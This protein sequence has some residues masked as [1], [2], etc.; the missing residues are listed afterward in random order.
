[1]TSFERTTAFVKWTVLRLI[2]ALRL[3]RSEFC[4]ADIFTKAVDKDTFFRMRNAMHNSSADE[5]VKLLAIRM[6][7]QPAIKKLA[8][9]FATW[10][11]IS[12]PV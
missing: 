11:P 6:W 7:K 3:V 12:F 10:G 5:S 9:F 4:I 8:E 2:I 1:M